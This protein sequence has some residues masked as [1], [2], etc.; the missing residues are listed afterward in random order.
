[1]AAGRAIKKFFVNTFKKR[2]SRDYGELLTRGIRGDRGENHVYPWLYIRVFVVMLVL[3][4]AYILCVRLTG[5]SFLIPSAILFG[6]LVFSLPFII[7]IYELYPRR[8]FSIISLVAVVILGGT[9]SVILVQIFYAIIPQS[10]GWLQSLR[11]G[12]VE[13]ICKALV[14]VLVIVIIKA[15]NPLLGFLIGACVGAG[16]SIVEDMGYLFYYSG[17][18][19]ANDIPQ[20]VNLFLQR[21]L[22]VF[23]THILW[24][25][26]AGWA[27]IKF[28]KAVNMVGFYLVMALTIGIHLLWNAPLTGALM[29]LIYALCIVF[30]AIFCITLIA[31]GRTKTLGDTEQM[32][33]YIS[34]AISRV[35]GGSF[36]RHAANITFFV[37]GVLLSVCA[38]VYCHLPVDISYGFKTFASPEEFISYA[39]NGVDVSADWSRPYDP[40]VADSEQLFVDGVLTQVVQKET[41]GE[42]T[43]YYYYYINGSGSSYTLFEIMADIPS[44]GG[45]YRYDYIRVYFKGEEYFSYFPVCESLSGVAIEDDGAVTVMT[46]DSEA[47]YERFPEEYA[48]VG[49]TAL[50][51]CCAEVVVYASLLIMGVAAD[52]HIKEDED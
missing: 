27:F 9:L 8:D 25:G 10:S 52:R 20:I 12:G 28:N 47:V 45:V 29:Y 33:I 35:R 32:E 51:L 34:P 49:W 2:T 21:G 5:S 30:C 44:G 46:Y 24:S 36:Y 18:W 3:F 37:L 43:I 16:F 1:M 19:V 7:L 11:A 48:P 22:S 4:S 6:G 42:C 38:L 14:C 23:C 39:Q 17:D 41:Q 40:I 13:E 31:L 15:D 26:M 50:G